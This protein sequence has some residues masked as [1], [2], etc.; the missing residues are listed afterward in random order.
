MLPKPFRS[1]QLLPRLPPPLQQ[2]PRSSG[3]LYHRS[4]SGLAPRA[5][6]DHREAHP[7]SP[8]HREAHPAAALHR[9]GPQR[10]PRLWL[11]LLKVS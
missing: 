5:S 8:D 4:T 9:N 10:H 1:P 6:P 3:R 7:A 2:L 11:P